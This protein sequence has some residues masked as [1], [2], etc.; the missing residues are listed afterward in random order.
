MKTGIKV[1]ER[2]V[3]DYPEQF[4]TLPAYSLHRGSI[5]T[6]IRELSDDEVD[7][8]FQPM[9]EVQAATGWIGHAFA[10]ELRPIPRE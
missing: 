3:F 2:Y 9:F 5:V 10:N 6:V 8:D 7:P 4:T 1:G